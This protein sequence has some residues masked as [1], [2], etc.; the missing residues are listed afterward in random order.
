MKREILKETIKALLLERE[1]ESLNEKSYLT[2]TVRDVK[3]TDYKV[4]KHKTFEGA[5]NQLVPPIR[6]FFKSVVGKAEGIDFSAQNGKIKTTKK[7]DIFKHMEALMYGKCS[8]EHTWLSMYKGLLDFHTTNKRGSY[9][10]L[11]FVKVYKH[12][13]KLRADAYLVDIEVDDI[14][15]YKQLEELCE[16]EFKTENWSQSMHGQLERVKIPVFGYI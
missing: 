10:K 6:E 13:N 1:R 7:D 4:I 12:G 5:A 9:K 16:L 14:D 11:V 15:D 2:G 3:K 8:S